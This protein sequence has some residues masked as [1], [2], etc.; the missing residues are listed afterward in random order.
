MTL[1]EA[2][3][4]SPLKGVL[5]RLYKKKKEKEYERAFRERLKYAKRFDVK[6]EDKKSILIVV[7]DCLRFKNTSLAKYERDTTPFLNTLKYSGKA[8]A[9]A[10]WTHPSVASMMTGM[11]PHNHGAYIHSKLKN[12]DNP[13]NFKGIRKGI[14]TLP[15]IAAL[16]GYNVYFATSIDVASFPMRGRSPLRLYPA[17]TRGGKIIRDFLQWLDG[18][19][20]A[21]F[22]Y[23]HLGDT[24]EPLNPPES[25]RNYFGKVKRL[26]NIERWA[27]QKPEE[28]KGR[29]FEEFRRNKLLLYDNTI[30]YV[31]HLFEWL[32]HELERRGLLED[33]LVIFTGDHG[34]EFWEHAKMEAEHFY[35]PRGIYGVGHGHN[36]FNEITEV[37]LAVE[38]PVKDLKMASR[39]LID[40][41]PTILEMWGVE[42]PYELDGRPLSR[43]PR[44]FLLTEATGYGYEKKSLTVGG[45]KFLYAPEDGVEWVFLLDKDPNE[46]RPVEDRD[47][48][49]FMR[50]RLLSILAKDEVKLKNSVR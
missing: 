43:K 15:E 8:T 40:L 2:V 4:R 42:L 14:I 36:V 21:F 38:G 7:A 5:H 9:A 39:S 13:K 20:G 25:F 34:E 49:E 23:L 19:R 47:V 22:A 35:D 6:I 46:S 10:P 32:H 11:Y 26:K 45:L 33:T 1:K 27:F 17:E 16:N 28:Q 18:K 50:K 24:H 41:A 48:T 44:K 31:D 37:P 12:F 29:E 3:L 30:R